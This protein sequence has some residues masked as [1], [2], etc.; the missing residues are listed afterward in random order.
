MVY[1][2]LM[3]FLMA[4]QVILCHGFSKI[5]N[6]QMGIR[7]RRHELIQASVINGCLT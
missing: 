4:G 6:G 5:K 7:R 3:D 2:L 1:S